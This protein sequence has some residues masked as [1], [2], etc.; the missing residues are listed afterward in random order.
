[1]CSKNFDIALTIIAI[2]NLVSVIFF[3]SVARNT[4]TSGFQEGLIKNTFVSRTAFHYIVSS[5]IHNEKVLLL[6]GLC[7]IFPL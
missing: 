6:F 4:E 5:V 7:S 1:M 3:F 2:F